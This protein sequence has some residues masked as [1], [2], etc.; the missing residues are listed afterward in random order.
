M[1]RPVNYKPNGL[2]QDGERGIIEDNIDNIGKSVEVIIQY[3]EG[4]S[5]IYNLEQRISS[6]TA[7]FNDY[8]N[9]ESAIFFL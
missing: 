8:D 6:E 2:Y 7:C 5:A 9:E 4:I 1:K 3:Q